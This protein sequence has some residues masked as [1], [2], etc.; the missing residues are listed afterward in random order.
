[1][2]KKTVLKK[3]TIYIQYINMM[4]ELISISV[5]NSCLETTDLKKKG[6][7]SKMMVIKFK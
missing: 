4:I 7:I 5:R 2:K 6:L 3:I 1:M